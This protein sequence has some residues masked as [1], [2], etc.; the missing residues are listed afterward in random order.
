MSKF[1]IKDYNF[2]CPSCGVQI[3]TKSTSIGDEIDCKSCS[4]RIKILSIS[5]PPYVYSV[6]VGGAASQMLPQKAANNAN[7]AAI[8][9]L[10]SQF[11]IISILLFFIS[12]FLPFFYLGDNG[13]TLLNILTDGGNSDLIGIFVLLVGGIM[14]TANVDM[15]IIKTATIIGVCF[16]LYRFYKIVSVGDIG[17]SYLQ[18]SFGIGGYL[19]L[20][21]AGIQLYACFSSTNE[22]D[23]I[24]KD[25]AEPQ[26]ESNLKDNKNSSNTDSTDNENSSDN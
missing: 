11:G 12:F 6:K 14:L 3:N 9:E 21:G 10:S 8:K 22:D 7:N 19:I 18:P 4:D 2:K 23:V 25:I 5:N 16:P 24:E 1:Y 17:S 15:N 13:V 26:K 20:I